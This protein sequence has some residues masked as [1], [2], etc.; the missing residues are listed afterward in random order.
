MKDSEIISAEVTEVIY[1][2]DRTDQ[3]YGVKFRQLGGSTFGPSPEETS[4]DNIA[5]PLNFNNV[6]IPIVGEVIVV[7]KAS[8]AL[9]SAM[10]NN[11]SNYYLDIISLQ[12]SLNHNA[13]PTLT[14]ATV[15]GGQA[16]AG[17]YQES[18]T[19]N[20]A[21]TQNNPKLDENFTEKVNIAPLQPFVGDTVSLSGTQFR[22]LTF[23][24]IYC[25]WCRNTINVLCHC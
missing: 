22:N 3:L 17:A 14:K 9:S 21:T 11:L 2:S 5:I 7:I 4:N 12:H 1:V 16:T 25:Y 23:S 6:R 20:T 13:L 24:K 8:N 19:G 18:S 15:S 10:R